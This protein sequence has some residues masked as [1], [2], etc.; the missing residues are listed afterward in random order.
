MISPSKALHEI[1][2]TLSHSAHSPARPATRLLAVSKTQPAEA[3]LALARLDQQAFGENY[4]QEAL[5]KIHAL[6]P[7]NLDLEWH[8]IGHLQSNKCQEV[9][10]NFSWVQSLDRVKLIEPLSRYRSAHRAPLN[11]LIQVNVD[12]E[13]SKFGCTPQAVLPLAQK[14]AAAPNLRLRGLMSIGAPYPDFEQR[15]ASFRRLRKLFDSLRHDFPAIDTLSMGMSED[16][17]LAIEEG[18]TMVRV[19]T[20]LFGARQLF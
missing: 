14:V 3:V 18:A 19:G 13:A 12:A 17:E 5:G 11:I 9:A 10:E 7:L 2:Q 15:R 16:Y 1:L 20:R 8:L 6:E 4:V